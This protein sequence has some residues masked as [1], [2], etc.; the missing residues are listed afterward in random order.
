MLPMTESSGHDPPRSTGVAPAMTNDGMD[1]AELAQLANAAT[2]APSAPPGPW[3][4]SIPPPAEK[5]LVSVLSSGRAVRADVWDAA[6]SRRESRAGGQDRSGPHDVQARLKGTLAAT[7]RRAEMHALDH[8]SP[9]GS[10]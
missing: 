5:D 4:G 1:V 3:H 2:S 8:S 10:P 6:A 7:R 9:A